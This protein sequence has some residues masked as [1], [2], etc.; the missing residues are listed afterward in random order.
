M[1]CGRTTPWPSRP[2]RPP[3]A[4]ADIQPG[5]L[6]FYGTPAY[7][8]GLYIGGGQM[9]EAAH[10]GTLVRIA[11]IHRPDLTAGARPG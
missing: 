3:V 5:D 4:I 11:D 7:H 8:V 1:W 2:A 6:V 9:I 10:T